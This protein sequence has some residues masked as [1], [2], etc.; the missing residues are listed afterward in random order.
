MRPHGGSEDDA[1]RPSAGRRPAVVTDAERPPF[2]HI[3]PFPGAPVQGLVAGQLPGTPDENLVELVRHLKVGGSYWAAQPPLPANYVLVRGESAL[4]AIADWPH[5][6]STVLWSD[7]PPPAGTPSLSIIGDCDPWH[8]LAGAIALITN[9]DDELCV[10]AA[11][12]GVPIHVVE[13]TT[14]QLMPFAADAR[15]LLADALSR[16]SYRDPFTGEPL[17]ARAAIELCGSWRR[18]IDSNRDIAGAI[19][20][21]FWKQQQVE[22]LLWGGSR[23]VKFFRTAREAKGDAPIA[24]WRARTPA[25]TLA[26][27][28]QAGVPLIEIEDGFLRSQGLGADC[29]PPLSI[30][31]DRLGAHFDPSAPSEI[32]HLLQDGE[33]G[34]GLLARARRLREMIVD[35]GLGKYERGGALID[36]PAGD[37]RHILVPGQV[38]DDRA[39][40]RGGCGLV[41]NL[42]LLARV[43][44]QAPDAFILYKPHPDVLAG[45]RTG[46]VSERECLQFADRIVTDAQVSSL[47]S[48]VDEVHVNT[49]LTGFEALLREKPVTTYGVPFYAG[50]GLTIDLGPVPARR[51]ARRTLDELVAAGLLLYPRYLDPETGLPC[52]AEV[53]VRRLTESHAAPREGIVVRLRRLQGRCRRGLAALRHWR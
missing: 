1:A 34:S 22:P 8:V 45:H 12:L 28:E 2:L 32:E 44:A 15:S 23:P 43:R 33:F 30:I 29:V 11:V 52:P 36:R 14:G 17:S 21:A 4:E 49:S 25:Q 47:I 46:A 27:L 16:H 39:V 40:Q 6:P 48:M 53:L 3:P 7:G 37:R 20:C 35:A 42:D 38:E 10:I 13:G 50:W 24:M 26:A 18:L 5:S 9:R 19:G 31:V 51:T 41:S